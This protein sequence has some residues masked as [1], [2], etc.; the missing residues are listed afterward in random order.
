M[1]APPQTPVIMK[2]DISFALSGQDFRAI[3]KMMANIDEQK[4]P[5]KPNPRQMVKGVDAKKRKAML[6]AARII[7]AFMYLTSAIFVSRNVPTKAPI[8]LHMKYT[9]DPREAFSTSN[10]HLSMS[11]FGETVLVPTSIPTRKH[12][13]RKQRRIS[14]FFNSENAEAT[15]VF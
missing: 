13:P 9:L 3:E 10:E 6:A 8:V 1:I 15:E 2:P 14:L 4:K 5:I 12:I 7:L 11:S